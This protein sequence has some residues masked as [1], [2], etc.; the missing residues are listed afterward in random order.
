[1]EYE[2]FRTLVSKEER[3]RVKAIARA[4]GMTLSG[5]LTWLVRAAIAAEERTSASEN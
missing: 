4:K 5:Y 1:M 3:K 2:T